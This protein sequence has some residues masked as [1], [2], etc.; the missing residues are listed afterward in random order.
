MSINKIKKI[1]LVTGINTLVY[2]VLFE[3]LA[4]VLLARI[5]DTALATEDPFMIFVL[6]IVGFVFFFVVGFIGVIATLCFIYRKY[7]LVKRPF[8]MAIV[9]QLILGSIYFTIQYHWSASEYIMNH[10]WSIVPI[11]LAA[12]S[13]LVLTTENK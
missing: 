7:K 5:L 2:I 8:L 13:A 6:F 3:L 1:L 11:V 10:M 12:V 9:P 4:R